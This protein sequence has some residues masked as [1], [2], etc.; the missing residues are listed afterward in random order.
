MTKFCLILLI[1]FSSIITNAQSYVTIQ[2]IHV[3]KGAGTKYETLGVLP[4]GSTVEVL[5][6][7]REWGKISFEGN[8]GYISTKFLEAASSENTSNT[9]NRS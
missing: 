5:G 9:N 3:R 4:K 2:D 8:N 7:T 1:L 6:L